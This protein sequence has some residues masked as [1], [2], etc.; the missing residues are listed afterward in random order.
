LP[1]RSRAPVEPFVADRVPVAPRAVA[2]VVVLR[3]DER[4]TA[5]AMTV[6]FL[7]LEGA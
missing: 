2:V 3:E 5:L 7:L 6:S 4:E 1:L